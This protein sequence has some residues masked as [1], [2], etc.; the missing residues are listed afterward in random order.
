VNRLSNENSAGQPGQCRLGW[1]ILSLP[2][3]LGAA[4]RGS[5][6]VSG[7]G[8][9]L[10]L[11]WSFAG[12]VGAS[13]A[14]RQTTRRAKPQILAAEAPRQRRRTCFAPDTCTWGQ[15]AFKLGAES[16]E[17]LDR[18]EHDPLNTWFVL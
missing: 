13:T 18:R 2:P 3:R 9:A 7:R 14:A 15:P 6:A 16:V 17:I 1:R 5:R 4:R 10:Q 8:Q 12:G 11:R